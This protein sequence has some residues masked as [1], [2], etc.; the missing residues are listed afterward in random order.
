[1]LSSS[2]PETKSLLQSQ[3]SRISETW[4]RGDY[5]PFVMSNCDTQAL[6]AVLQAG[7][8]FNNTAVR[9][10]I[11]GSLE[12]AQLKQTACRVSASPA[13]LAVECV[14]LFTLPRWKHGYPKLAPV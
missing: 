12:L 6:E 10:V 3:E 5:S 8:F 14:A 2:I 13:Q 11:N 1:M 7:F 9:L 4:S